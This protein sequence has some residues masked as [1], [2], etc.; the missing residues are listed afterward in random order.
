MKE[1]KR[2]KAKLEK[3]LMLAGKKAA[4]EQKT[5]KTLCSQKDKTI[6]ELRRK[7]ELTET[8][9]VTARR[10]RWRLRS[11]SKRRIEEGGGAAVE[12]D[13]YGL[14]KNLLAAEDTPEGRAECAKR[15]PIS[16][17]TKRRG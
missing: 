14:A 12:N 16:P 4:S 8:S 1:T 10:P 11:R 7:V 13:D 2:E 6:S 17:R 9:D 5:L 15:L 3:E